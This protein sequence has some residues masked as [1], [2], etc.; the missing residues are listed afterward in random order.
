MESAVAE[1]RGSRGGQARTRRPMRSVAGACGA[2]RRDSHVLREP[3]TPIR[4][5]L[6]PPPSS[7]SGRQLARA[8]ETRHRLV[9]RADR[10]VAGLA[11]D[12]H[13][14]AVRKSC[15]RPPSEAPERCLDD[16][17]ILQDQP[18]VIEQH[19]DGGGDPI[20]TRTVDGG[21][22]P[23]GFDEHWMRN[24]CAGSHEGLGR[25]DLA[26]II[27]NEQPDQDARIN[28]AHVCVA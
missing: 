9:E 8:F 23:D 16:I 4:A 21:K 18:I 10:L 28:G 19:A 6:D 11:G 25:F 27:T 7:L 17:S 22:H 3:M 20:R 15:R 26:R 13:D 12:L 1:R 2:G 24:P 14:E 5:V